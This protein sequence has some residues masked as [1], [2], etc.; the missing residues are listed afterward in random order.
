MEYFSTRS[1]QDR[2]T[3]AQAI[4]QGL[5]PD[6][7]L[8]LPEEFPALS[9]SD[10][11]ELTGMNDI[12]R[13]CKVLG[14]Y[15]TD[16]APEEIRRCVLAAYGEGFDSER[17]APIS[18]LDE[19]DYILELWHGPTCAFKDMALQLLPHLMTAAMRIVG[20]KRTAVILAATSGD[21]GKAALEGFCDVP[22]TKVM[23]FYPQDG[24]STMQKLQMQTQQGGNVQVTAVQ[25]NFD[26]AQTGVK[27]IFGD[28]QMARRM[29][30]CGAFLTSANSMNWG[31]LLPQ[32]VYYISA[33]CQ[34]VADEEI[35]LGDVIDI[36][37][38]TGNFG[39]ILAGY[40]AKRM[41]LPLGRLVCAS[42]ENHVLTDFLRT[43]DYDRNRPFYATNS[44][45]MDIL[46]SSNLERLL[47]H[48]LGQDGLVRERMQQLAG[49]GEYTI[50]AQALAQLQREFAGYY[51]GEAGTLAAIRRVFERYSYLLDTHTAVAYDC[52][53]QYRS[54]TGSD[55][56]MLILSTASPYKFPESVASALGID[57]AGKEGLALCEEIARRTG[58]PIPAPLA[59]LGEKPLRFSEEIPCSRMAEH[60]L[61]FARQ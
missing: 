3:A 52:A 11:E 19:Q 39:N 32:I 42:N 8:F 49:C 60:V 46:V 10:L 2:V 14:L 58:T 23:V 24:V 12:D 20:E 35:A 28:A 6:G 51:C 30:E 55:R 54:Q 13:C 17:I 26:D 43:G 56:K 53:C 50:P 18:K 33:Y 41:G 21:T 40:Y 61:R 1:Q 25:G 7:G 15:L 57:P 4:A 29:E 45:S 16:F 59:A 44:P 31:R 22:Q 48:L 38:P 47:W 34:L 5:A 9:Q 37:V 27:A 36:C